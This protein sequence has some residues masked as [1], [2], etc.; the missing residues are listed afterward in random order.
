M[1]LTNIDRHH[2]K[3]WGNIEFTFCLI[4]N[5]ILFLLLAFLVLKP[6]DPNLESMPLALWL[7]GL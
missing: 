2:P 6:T 3:I 7:S 5:I 1:A 4:W